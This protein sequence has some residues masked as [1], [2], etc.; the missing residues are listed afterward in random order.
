MDTEYDNTR[1]SLNLY[2]KHHKVPNQNMIIQGNLSTYTKSIRE[3]PNSP[4]QF[5]V[6]QSSSKLHHSLMTV[7][8]RNSSILHCEVHDPIAIS[9]LRSVLRRLKPLP[10]LRRI[11][12][13]CTHTHKATLNSRPCT[14]CV[15]E[16]MLSGTMLLRKMT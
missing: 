4:N 7:F 15:G 9:L 11:Y 8:T 13:I 6:K 1:K 14:L 16:C 12:F 2:K 10:N 5:F 3:S